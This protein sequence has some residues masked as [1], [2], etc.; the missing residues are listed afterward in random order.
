MYF[1]TWMNMKTT[2]LFLLFS[3]LT[4]TIS[5]SQ[6]CLDSL[7]L[8]NPNY[9]GC[10]DPYYPVCGCDGNTYRNDC[11]AFFKGAINYWSKGSCSDFDYSIDPTVVSYT[12]KLQVFMK[13]AGTIAV[14]IYDVYGQVF[15]SQQFFVAETLSASQASP[16]PIS[17]VDTFEQGVYIIVIIF[18][19]EKKAKKFYKSSTR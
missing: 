16:L 14:S 8:P 10:F 12:L 7:R 9:L 18:N 15:Y 5:F 1:D 6:S 13:Y 4:C 19:G 2:K 3:F 17:Q 11:D